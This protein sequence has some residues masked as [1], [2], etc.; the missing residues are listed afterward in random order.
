MVCKLTEHDRDLVCGKDDRGLLS[1]SYYNHII[2][3][4]IRGMYFKSNIDGV[5]V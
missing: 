5:E 1:F 2:C 3:F 4:I